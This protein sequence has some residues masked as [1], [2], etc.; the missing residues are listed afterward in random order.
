MWAV[1]LAAKKAILPRIQLLLPA[2]YIPSKEA[3]AVASIKDYRKAA[4][5]C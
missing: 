3:F 4:C 1:L 2:T 5:C